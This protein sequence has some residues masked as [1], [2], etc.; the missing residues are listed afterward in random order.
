MIIFLVSFC[1]F[2]QARGSSNSPGKVAVAVSL[3]TMANQRGRLS[4]LR[5]TGILGTRADFCWKRSYGR[6]VGT[7]PNQCPEGQERKGLLCHHKCKEGYNGVGFL[8]WKNCPEGY[9]GGIFCKRH[10]PVHWMKRERYNRGI[11][12]PMV[13]PPEK[14]NRAGLCYNKCKEHFRGIGPVCWGECQAPYSFKCGATCT[15][16]SHGCAREIFKIVAATAELMANV[17][18]VV[19]TAGG[20]AAALSAGKAA[21]IAAGRANAHVATTKLA[22]VATKVGIKDI[23]LLAGQIRDAMRATVHIQTDTM[24]KDIPM[25]VAESAAMGTPI[26]WADMDPT[27]V[28]RLVQTL[29]RP[30][31][32]E[33]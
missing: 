17:A 3:N 21:S 18:L 9:Q 11:G 32:D 31:C 25:L 2:V 29:K 8:C 33:L 7:I 23:N 26:N 20:A 30:F 28:A 13:C 22:K 24:K 16:S 27:G 15:V 19:I 12:T 14:E 6:G 5:K 1:L 10:K 4:D